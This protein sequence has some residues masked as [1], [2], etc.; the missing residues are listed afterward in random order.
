MV[1]RPGKVVLLL[2][3]SVLTTLA[4]LLALYFCVVAFGGGLALATVGAVYLVGS[5]VASAAPT[6]GGLGAME[7]ALIGGL[8]AAGLSNE[9][10]VPA[11]FLF[12]LATFWLPILPGWLCFEW[13]QRHDYV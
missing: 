10:A 11:V 8:V 5:A 2:G 4:Y 1:R 3:G 6:P 9:V 13:L 12:R 7:A